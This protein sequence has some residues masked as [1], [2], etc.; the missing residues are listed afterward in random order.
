MLINTMVERFKLFQD[1]TKIKFI[2]D[3]FYDG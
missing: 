3:L 1:C 2:L